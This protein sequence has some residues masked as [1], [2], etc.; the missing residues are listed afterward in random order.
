[1]CPPGTDGPGPEAT[2]TRIALMDE[3][4][5]MLDAMRTLLDGHPSFRV[6]AQATSGAELLQAVRSQRVDLV[7]VEPWLRSDGALDALR[8]ISRAHPRVIIVALS[9]MWDRDHVDPL[10]EMGAQ[11]YIPKSTAL[12]RIP[13]ILHAAVD[14]MVT[15]PAEE[16]SGMARTALL[17]PRETEVLAM[18]AEG[19]DNRAIA[20][21]L[22]VTERTV[23]FHLQNAYRKLGVTNRTA[24]AA[25]ARRLGIIQ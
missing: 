23:K 10:V 24:A 12:D 1:M 22:V 4:P 20:G 14:G 25:A 9:R 3:Y 16:Q 17:T 6:V 5:A 21:A 15:L 7:L 13:P 18:A 19:M 11:A 2:P 8:E